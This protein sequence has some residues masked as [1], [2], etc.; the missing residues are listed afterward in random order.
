MKKSHSITKMIEWLFVRLFVAS[1][2]QAPTLLLRVAVHHWYV[3]HRREVD[4]PEPPQELLDRLHRSPLVQQVYPARPRLRKGKRH[5][6]EAW[7]VLP[8]PATVLE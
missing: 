6:C 2:I 3:L 5:R 7:S 1:S 8:T 4:A